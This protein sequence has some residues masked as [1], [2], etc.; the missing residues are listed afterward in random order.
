M[1]T[2]PTRPSSPTLRRATGRF[3]RDV[4][5]AALISLLIAGNPRFAEL[6][7]AGTVT[8][9]REDRK[10]IRH[11]SVGPVEV[12][13]DVLTDGDSELKI[14]VMTAAPGSPDETAL[15]LAA[16]AGIVGG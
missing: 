15:R 1:T 14:V 7:A 8:A 6:W 10:T 11:P 16:V 5:L 2:P 12:S 9:H 4:R 3:P 13:C